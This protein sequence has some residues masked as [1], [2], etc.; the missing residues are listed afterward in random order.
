MRALA[1]GLALPLCACV[2][3]WKAGWPDASVTELG[4]EAGGDRGAEAGRDLLADLPAPLPGFTWIDI[5]PGDFEMGAPVSVP[6]RVLPGET[7]Q[8]VRLSHAYQLA[9][10]ETTQGQ[11]ISL[12]GYTKLD[13][14]RL[15]HPISRVSWHEAT[16]FCNTLSA[17]EGRPTCYHCEAGQTARCR[18]KGDYAGDRILSCAGYRLPTEAEWE[19]AYR[20]GTTGPLYLPVGPKP[21]C[22]EQNPVASAIGWYAT[23]AGGDSHPV[24]QKKPNAWGI[25]DLAGNV[26]EWCLDSQLRTDQPVAKTWIDP[27]GDQIAIRTLRG[28]AFPD[29]AHALRASA[30][31]PIGWEFYAVSTGFRCARTVPRLFS[32]VLHKLSM[33]TKPNEFALDIDGS[34]PKNALG[35][36]MLMMNTLGL[37]FQE[38]LD[39]DLSKGNLIILLEVHADSHVYGTRAVAQLHLGTDPDGD[40]QNNFSGSTL[41]IK[42]N[43]PAGLSLKGSV[44]N[45]V[46]SLRGRLPFPLPLTLNA[47]ATKVLTL[48]NA[49]IEAKYT[50]NVM[51]ILAGAVTQADF[52][53]ILVPA[54]AETLTWAIGPSTPLTPIE[55]D[56]LAKQLDLNSDG[57]ITED[58][59]RQNPIWSLV[60]PDLD[61]DHDGKLDAF[62]VAV[63]F[64]AVP[65]SIQR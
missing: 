19:H 29:P 13:V 52:N 39:N 54:V 44:V 30:R 23:N 37:R 32:G 15:D 2:L 55:R 35:M 63:A 25:Y 8:S 61:L 10:T 40:P 65:C 27:F 58:E 22:A 60:L 51:G 20:A 43:N 56:A 42:G 21:A 1:L 24:G 16:S 41:A 9:S 46:V 28:G 38:T 17:R 47:P 45:S 7:P 18:P 12:M 33:P 59:L 4:L 50:G 57:Q 49:R 34:G 6:C 5:A 64:E 26:R 3:D 53:G 62:S 36:M 11:F 31:S 48:A 14:I